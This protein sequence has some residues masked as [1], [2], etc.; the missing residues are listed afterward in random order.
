MTPEE[1]S[2]LFPPLSNE[3]ESVH[4]SGAARVNGREL[5]KALINAAKKHGAIFVRGSAELMHST[6]EIT[7]V[8]VGNK[9]YSADKVVITAGAWA[10]ELLA[11]L[12]INLQVKGQKAQ[13]VHLQLEDEKIQ[14]NGLLSCRLQI[15]IYWHLIM[16]ESLLVRR[17]KMTWNTI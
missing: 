13:I 4:I 6:N 9:Q 3:F 1:T 5:V 14:K 8:S 16:A 12:G 17:M 15:N 2:S 11:P 7:G 10:G